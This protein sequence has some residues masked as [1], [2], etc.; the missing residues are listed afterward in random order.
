M[1]GFNRILK[2]DER[3]AMRTLPFCQLFDSSAT[4]R[5]A[6][7]RL[8]TFHLGLEQCEDRKLMSVTHHK[9]RPVTHHKPASAVIHKLPSVR[10]SQTGDGARSSRAAGEARPDF[11]LSTHFP[12]ERHPSRTR[13]AG[14]SSYLE[15]NRRPGW[16]DLRRLIRSGGHRSDHG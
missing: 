7:R 8:R 15:A 13:P 12:G 11:D 14:S 4:G 10:A 1:F 2:K 16:L 9:L 3:P 5:T 6:K